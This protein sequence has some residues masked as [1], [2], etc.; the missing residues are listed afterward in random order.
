MEG[1]GVRE[2]DTESVAERRRLSVARPGKIDISEKPTWNL[3]QVAS[4]PRL[5][6]CCE[7]YVIS[8]PHTQ[9]FRQE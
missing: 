3:F 5:N 8:R 2:N 1:T 7:I 6:L 9:P 4:K